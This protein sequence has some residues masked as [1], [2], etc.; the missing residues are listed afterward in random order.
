[1]IVAFSLLSIML[2]VSQF[3][4]INFFFCDTV[5][6]SMYIQHNER[7][8]MISYKYF[9]E[10]RLCYAKYTTM[11]CFFF[12]FSW[13]FPPPHEQSDLVR[14]LTIFFAPKICEQCFS[15]QSWFRAVPSIFSYPIITMER[16]RKKL[17]LGRWYQN[18]RLGSDFAHTWT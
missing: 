12:L 3:S 4:P 2:I 11:S 6:S 10:L 1:M 14:R 15:W 18:F 17:I 13:F 16:E 7:I 5:I 9:E 8:M